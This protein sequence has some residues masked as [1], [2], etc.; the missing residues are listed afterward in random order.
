MNVWNVKLNSSE[1]FIFWKLN[2]SDI[3]Q[4]FSHVSVER[5]QLENFRTKT[6]RHVKSRI[7]V[8][9]DNWRDDK[10]S[11]L[12]V[13][14]KRVFHLVE[15]NTPCTSWGQHARVELM[16]VSSETIWSAARA[17]NDEWHNQ[18]VGESVNVI[19]NFNFFFLL[20]TFLVQLSSK[21]QNQIAEREKKSTF[22]YFECSLR[23]YCMFVHIKTWPTKSANARTKQFAI[24][25]RLPTCN[26]SFA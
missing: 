14:Q 19:K 12:N 26:E 18:Q 2:F 17:S 1:K 4:L 8:E 15:L 16:N 5:W 25:V 23:V 6:W 10:I 9:R 22:S 20:S 21:T 3:F 7:S 13:I 11:E 24:F